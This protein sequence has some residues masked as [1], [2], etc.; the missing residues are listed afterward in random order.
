MVSVGRSA[1][2]IGPFIAIVALLASCAAPDGGDPGAQPD[3]PTPTP[4]ATVAPPTAADAPPGSTTAPEATPDAAEALF[5]GQVATVDGGTLDLA[6]LAGRDVAA[7]FW[8][9]W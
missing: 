5:H 9:P 2:R 7:W 6:A 4:A 1:R 3:A 8:A